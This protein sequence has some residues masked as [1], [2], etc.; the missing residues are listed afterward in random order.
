MRSPDSKLYVIKKHRKQLTL[1]SKELMTNLM[2]NLLLSN[3]K[4]LRIKRRFSNKKSR[5]LHN[6]KRPS[7]MIIEIAKH[8]EVFLKIQKQKNKDKEISKH[9]TAFK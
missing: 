2:Q 4:M 7:E 8:R 9:A 6:K 1:K 3:R 5:N